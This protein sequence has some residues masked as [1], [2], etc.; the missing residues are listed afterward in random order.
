MS[1]KYIARFGIFASIALVLGWLE[2]CIPIAAGIPG[3]KLGLANTML[4]YAIYLLDR[5]GAWLLMAVKVLLS[6]LLFS[7]LTG[8]LYSM[9]G[10]ICSLAV[11]CL[12]KRIKG[13]S[14]L[15]ASMAGALTHNIAQVAVACFVVQ[16]RAVLAYLPVLLIAG[17][18]TGL[19]TG[20]IAKYTMRAISD[21]T[22]AFD[23]EN[24]K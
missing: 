14:I 10:G 16:S 15:G 20:I 6:G 3:I 11:M 21:K 12:L 19:L 13:F 4:L 2:S 1:A 8:I 7:G 24:E 23:Q 18:V 22:P 5:K 9:A 17:T